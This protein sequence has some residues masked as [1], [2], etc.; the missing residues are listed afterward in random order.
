MAP[1]REAEK[2][3]LL[4]L[5]DGIAAGTMDK[6]KVDAAIATLTTA[7]DAAHE[8]SVD[9]LNQLHAIL[10]PAER[11]ALVDK[12]QA[13]WEVWRQAITRRR[14]AG[15]NAAAGSRTSLKS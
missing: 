11:A 8:A 1:A 2:S 12:V 7:A 3:L 13:H 14:L 6:V 10:S 5:A 9:T 4:T 15:V